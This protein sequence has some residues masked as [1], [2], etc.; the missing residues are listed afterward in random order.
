M[1]S[2]VEGSESKGSC[3]YSGVLN[4]FNPI[5]QQYLN[6]FFLA[7]VPELLVERE[8]APGRQFPLEDKEIRGKLR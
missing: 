8:T 1:I 2:V 4:P 7:S 6:I 5:Q 3:T